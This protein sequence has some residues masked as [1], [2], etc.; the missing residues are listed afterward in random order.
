MNITECGGAGAALSRVPTA[1][2]CSLG[3]RWVLVTALFSIRVAIMGGHNAHYG[4]AVSARW[5]LVGCSLA[6]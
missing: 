1:P 3:A 6:A 5:L 4:R 2:E